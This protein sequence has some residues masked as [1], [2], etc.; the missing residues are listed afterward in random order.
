MNRSFAGWL[1]DN[2]SGA[3]L[4]T[5]LLGLLPLFGLVFAFFLPGAVPALLTLQRGPRAGAA[6]A[7]GAALMLAVA[8]WSIGRPPQVGLVYAAWML[9]PPM[10]LAVL[11]GRTRSLSLCLQIATLAGVA[12]VLLLHAVF[13]DP[14][15]FWQSWLREL[16]L[17][18]QR[19]GLPMAVD[20]DTFVNALAR[21]MWGWIAVLTMLLA[22]SALLLARWWQSLG[23]Q[24]G[25]FAAE[26]RELRLGRVL[27]TVSVVAIGLALWIDNVVVADLARLLLCAL[28]LVGLAAVHRYRA[29]RNLHAV[30]LWI[31]Y[32]GLVL[33]SPI[34]VPALAGWGFV[35]NWV[36]SGRR[37][38]TA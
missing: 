13:G 9:A 3:V 34:M 24:T 11:L 29:E 16:V 10:L 26:F 5:G 6:V 7:L 8:V 36:R 28:L 1:A 30:W 17:E 25:S 23:G 15:Q 33:V 20:A 18:M 32:V 22:M 21:T 38:S 2:P 37:D 4:V 19:Q 35:D 12:L 14:M 27:G 31:T